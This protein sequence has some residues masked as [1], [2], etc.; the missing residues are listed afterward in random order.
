MRQTKF[1]CKR[2]A[3]VFSVGILAGAGQ[4]TSPAYAADH[5]EKGG[6]GYYYSV[7]LG[8]GFTQ[9]T[10]FSGVVTPPGGQQ[11]VDIDFGSDFNFGGSIGMYLPYD[12]GSFTPRVELELSHLSSDADS[13]D[14]TGNGP[15]NENNTDGD[16]S[17]TLLMVNAIVDFQTHGVLRP[18]AGAGIGAAF[19]DIDIVY[20][21]P[22]GAPPPIR[23]EDSDTNFAAQAILGATIDI[24]SGTS[25]FFDGRYTRVF[26]VEGDRF[27]P[28][29]LTGTIEDDVSNFS[30]NLGLKVDF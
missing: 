20:G 14:F 16:Y 25:L 10:D 24:S 17:R 28:G 22:P 18:Y 11:S 9:D 5:S 27:N 30:L 1:C 6:N 19:S 21:G 23:F 15:G 2:W 8:A 26:G 4:I 29:G 13:L 3:A 7:F 12:S